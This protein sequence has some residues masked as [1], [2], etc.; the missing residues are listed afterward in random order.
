MQT[1]RLLETG[2]CH[3]SEEEA[4]IGREDESSSDVYGFQSEASRD[5]QR[6][7]S[8]HSA[9]AK[10]MMEDALAVTKE[11]HYRAKA[12]EGNLAAGEATP[13]KEMEKA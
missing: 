13:P 7:R 11:S 3:A 2:S 10:E 12:L 6:P 1:L 8:Q 9:L 5:V 4:E